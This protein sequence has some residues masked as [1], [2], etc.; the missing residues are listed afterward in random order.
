MSGSLY[1]IKKCK[2]LLFSFLGLASPIEKVIRLKH[3]LR[4]YV[5]WQEKLRKSLK[6][7]NGIKN[8]YIFNLKRIFLG[9]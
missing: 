5:M 1:M 2:L 8:N 6:E 9:Y 4:L 7:D 3:S